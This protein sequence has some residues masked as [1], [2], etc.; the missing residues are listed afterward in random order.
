MIALCCVGCAWETT[1][2]G[3]K[4]GGVERGESRE[5][6]GSSGVKAQEEMPF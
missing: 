3:K 2:R 4:S 5:H 1:R 6:E